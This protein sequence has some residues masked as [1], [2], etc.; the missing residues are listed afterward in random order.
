MKFNLMIEQYEI[1]ELY[2]I[3]ELKDEINSLVSKLPGKR[4]MIFMMSRDEG[5]SNKEISEKLSIS[6]QTVKNQ[7]SESLKFIRKSLKNFYIL[8]L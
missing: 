8:F 4:G 7:I 6:L 1:E 5:L 2:E 3:D